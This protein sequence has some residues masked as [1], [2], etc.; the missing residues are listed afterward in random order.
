M[1]NIN[2][3]DNIAINFD[4]DQDVL[5][6]KG[7]NKKPLKLYRE[8]TKFLAKNNFDK[9][10][11]S[12]YLSNKKIN[13]LQVLTTILDLN[14]ELPWFQPSVDKFT[15]T[16]KNNIFNLIPLI[17]ENSSFCDF[18]ASKENE[19]MSVDKK[20]QI[21]LNFDLSVQ[22]IDK[23]CSYRSKPYRQIEKVMKNHNFFHQQG[24]GYISENEI[25]KLELFEIVNELKI[26]VRHFEDIVKHLDSTHLDKIW[27]LKSYINNKN[28]TNQILSANNLKNKKKSSNSPQAEMKI[29]KEIEM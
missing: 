6:D 19:L 26:N 21:A 5:L 24:S 8:L 7:K 4:L 23:Y 20:K 25:S 14:K 16:Y 1:E 27:D 11:Q 18:S 28:L 9:M 17:H 29:A 12:S 13:M 10:Q 3:K 22:A 15:A 2:L